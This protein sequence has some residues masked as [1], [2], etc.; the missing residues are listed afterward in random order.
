MSVMHTTLFTA[1]S[2]FGLQTA[3]EMAY[4]AQ[5][6][7]H[8]CKQAKTSDD[9]RDAALNCAITAWHICEWVW[10][11]IAKLD[12]RSKEIAEVLGVSGRPMNS[13]DVVA[14]AL[15]KCPELEICQSIC[16]GTKHVNSE[17]SVATTMAAPDPAERRPGKQLVARAIVIGPDG[18]E[19]NIEDVLGD[20]VYFWLAQLTNLGAMR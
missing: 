19:Q 11:G 2:S 20:V 5:R 8:R 7:Y 4:K 6:D 17:K 12:R 15:R 16:N 14:W 10:A 18:V 1:T 3:A 13:N 9:R